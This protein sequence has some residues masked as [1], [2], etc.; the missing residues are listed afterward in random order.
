[1]YVSKLRHVKIDRYFEYSYHFFLGYLLQMMYYI[2]YSNL[3]E[4]IEAENRR[5]TPLSLLLYVFYTLELSQFE[6]FA[7]LFLF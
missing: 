4:G 7:D 3:I 6:K 2:V 1:M 5:F